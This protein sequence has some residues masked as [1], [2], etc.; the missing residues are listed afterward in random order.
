MLCRW[1]S[2]NDNDEVRVAQQTVGYRRNLTRRG[3]GLA[4]PLPG[5]TGL[6][7][8]GRTYRY[9]FDAVVE[10]LARNPQWTA[11][12]RLADHTEP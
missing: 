1:H 8:T 6:S 11:W 3:H 9:D 5:L 7:D 4:A 10:V 2:P 12:A